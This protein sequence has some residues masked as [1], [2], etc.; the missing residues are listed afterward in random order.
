MPPPTCR[1]TPDG[2]KQLNLPASDRLAAVPDRGVRHE[3][4]PR[5]PPG[6]LQ[7]RVPVRPT[8]RRSHVTDHARTDGVSDDALTP[9]EDEALSATE[10][11]G[12]SSSMHSPS[13]TSTLAVDCGHASIDEATTLAEKLPAKSI[14]PFPPR[15]APRGQLAATAARPVPQQR[16]RERGRRFAPFRRA[17][18]VPIGLS[19]GWPNSRPAGRRSDQ[20]QSC[21]LWHRTTPQ[22]GW[23]ESR[24][25]VSCDRPMSPR[26]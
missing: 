17:A 19:S 24:T 12:T 3:A 20:V 4:P 1:I 14:G 18:A 9:T 23:L 22:D 6:R 16:L 2:L 25:P 15:A 8:K 10:G 11:V 7:H 13:T 26:R 21:A 5:G